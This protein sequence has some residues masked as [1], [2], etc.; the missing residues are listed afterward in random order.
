MLTIHHNVMFNYPYDTNFPYHCINSIEN[1]ENQA[2]TKNSKDYLLFN[3]KQ[4]KVFASNTNRLVKSRHYMSMY[5]FISEFANDKFYLRYKDEI[6]RK[7]NEN[8]KN[9]DKDKNKI[10]NKSDS[11]EN[12]SATIFNQYKIEMIVFFIFGICCQKSR[13]LGPSIRIK[14]EDWYNNYDYSYYC[15][16]WINF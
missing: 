14:L 5:D 16:I 12:Y 10:N 9:G 7:D 2:K 11:A 8:N 13:K 3:I 1:L 4:D 6:D 15:K